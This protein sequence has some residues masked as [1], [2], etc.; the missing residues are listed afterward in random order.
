M[1]AVRLDTRPDGKKLAEMKSD[2]SLVFFK[3]RR[4]KRLN[5]ER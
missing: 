1:W 2:C 5:M 3:S 4:K